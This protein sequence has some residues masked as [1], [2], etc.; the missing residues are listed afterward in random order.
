MKEISVNLLAQLVQGQVEGNPEVMITGVGKIDAAQPGD[1]VFLSNPKYENYL[2][3]TKASVALV[4]NDFKATHAVSCTLVRVA[5]PYSAFAILLREYEK[6]QRQIDWSVHPSSIIDP[7]VQIPEKISIGAFTY[8]G[9]GAKLAKGCII[10]SHVTLGP[11]VVL[12]EN[13]HIHAGARLLK[14][15]EVGNR[16]VIQANSVIGSDGFGFAPQPDGSYMP[17]PQ[18]GNVELEDDVHI[19]ANCTIDRATTGTTRI[20]KGTKLDNLIQVAHNVEIGSHT[21]VAAQTGIAGSTKIGNF[22]KI[23][24]QVGIAG[25]IHLADGTQIAAQSGIMKTIKQ[26]NKAWFGSPAFDL[27]DYLKAS[28]VFRKL[29][30]L[31]KDVEDLKKQEP[32]N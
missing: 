26:P 28:A 30:Q 19:G 21:V 29:P 8:I 18:L 15:T 20:K 25:H 1:L 3:E 17:I 12:G 24:G 11:N 2:Y 16:C 23:G 6:W 9:P 13:C 14:G 27:S 31:W 7:S 22:N 4:S 5:D 10:E 32:K